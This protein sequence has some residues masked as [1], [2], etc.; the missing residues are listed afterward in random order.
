MGEEDN[1]P[2]TLNI[3]T[4]KVFRMNYDDMKS[5]VVTYVFCFIV[6]GI[7]MSLIIYGLYLFFPS[8]FPSDMAVETPLYSALITAALLS[9]ILTIASH[10]PH[11]L[12][13]G[14]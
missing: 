7:G 6:V 1:L 13:R 14:E 2:T 5:I 11:S 3:Q 10:S 9:A 12:N 4:K 8:D